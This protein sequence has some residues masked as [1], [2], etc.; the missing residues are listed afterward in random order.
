MVGEIE[1]KLVRHIEIGCNSVPMRF[2]H[3]ISGI[4][5]IVLLPELY[6]SLRVAFEVYACKILYVAERK[7]FVVHFEHERA[8]I[9]GKMFGDTGKFQ[10]IIAETF[11]VHFIGY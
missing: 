8:F 6:R 5:G 10:A 11:Y 1:N 7:H 9:K 3:V 4:D 2:I